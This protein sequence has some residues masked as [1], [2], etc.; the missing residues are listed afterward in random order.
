MVEL[1]NHHWIRADHPAERRAGL[2]AGPDATVLAVLD[3]HRGLRG[4]YTAAGTLLRQIVPDALTRY[5]DLVHRHD[6]E[7]LSVAPELRAVVPASRETLTSLAVP[8]ERTRFYSRLRTARLANGLT[9]FLH[10][11][12]RRLG[13]GPRCLLVDNLHQADPTDQELFAVLLRRA[14]RARLCLHLATAADPPADP[15]GPVPFPLGAALARYAAVGPTPTLDAEPPTG[16]DEELA[17]RYV[18]RDG[19]AADDP[20][21]LGAYQRLDPAR[22]AALHDA[23]GDELVGTGEESLRLGAVPYHREHGS[24]PTKA[25]VASLYEALFVGLDNGFYHATV[26][27]G[28]RGL[29]LVDPATQPIPWWAFITKM[30]TSLSALG[31]GE[32]AIELYDEARARTTDPTQQRQAAYATAMLYTRHLGADR[33]NQRLARAWSNIAI[34]LTE[35]IEDPTERAFQSAFQRNGLALVATHDGE[36]DE[37]LRLVEDGID[38]LDRELDDGRHALHRS[39]LRHNRSMLHLGAG[40]FEAALADLDAVIQADPNYAEYRFD[41][42]N[43]LRRMNRPIEA[44]ADYE[45]ALTLSPPFPEV[46]YNRGDTRLELGDAEGAEADFGYVLEL[47]PGYVDAYLNRAGLRLAAGDLTAA[48]EDVAAGLRVDPGNPHLLCVRGQLELADGDPAAAERTLSAALATAPDL[49]AGW[50]ARATAHY[51][52]DDVP[53]AL[54]DLD[55]ALSLRDDP[56]MRF[57]RAVLRAA[58]G[59]HAE[60][61]ADLTVAGESVDDPQIR[62]ERARSLLALGETAAA[63]DDLRACAQADPE[64]ADQVRHLRP[65]LLGAGR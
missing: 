24:D 17:R 46:Y 3:A 26:E 44:L 37:A 13:G 4:P 21:L 53:A 56:E 23:R 58:A 64:L 40:R 2:V 29:A 35:A 52:L 45:T 59:R 62:W 54:A 49:A 15:P 43:L 31:R 57:N 10:G 7:I 20:V 30:T 48:A 5:P 63:D 28:R 32:E 12:L 42:G 60:A 11:Y 50:A 55:R 36:P 41:R 18:W 9:E 19:V 34:A 14:D 51:E 33:H 65:E 38:R 47:D 8:T 16:D 39:V 25:G 22:R 27:L 61:V 1:P 6:I